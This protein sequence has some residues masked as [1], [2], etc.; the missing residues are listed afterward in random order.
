MRIEKKIKTKIS[1]YL[2]YKTYHYVK[3]IKF[4]IFSIKFENDLIIFHFVRDPKNVQ[5]LQ[6]TIDNG[7]FNWFL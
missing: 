6:K 4:I 5:Y 1:K 3:F 2:T 7:K